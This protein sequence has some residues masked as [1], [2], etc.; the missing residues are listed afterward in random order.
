MYCY[1]NTIYCLKQGV[2]FN[3]IKKLYN[4]CNAVTPTDIIEPNFFIIATMYS[5]HLPFAL[6]LLVNTSFNKRLTK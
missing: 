4:L 3:K 6:L 1:Y 2:L 5:H